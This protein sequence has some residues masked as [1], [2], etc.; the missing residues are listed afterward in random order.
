MSDEAGEE[1]RCSLMTEGEGEEAWLDDEE[2]DW[3][4]ELHGSEEERGDAVKVDAAAAVDID[5]ESE[6]EDEE[7]DGKVPAV[8]QRTTQHLSGSHSGTRSAISVLLL[9]QPKMYASYCSANEL[10]CHC[11]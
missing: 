9:H 10:G 3:R 1:R 8:Q 6:V 11:R 2:S 5:V 7:A 4:K